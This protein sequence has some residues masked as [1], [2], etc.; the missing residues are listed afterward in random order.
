MF[1]L[2]QE[3]MLTCPCCLSR[4]EIDHDRCYWV[5][6]C[7]ECKHQV[8]II[9]LDYGGMLLDTK[10]FVWDWINEHDIP[11]NDNTLFDDIHRYTIRFFQGNFKKMVFTDKVANKCSED[12]Y[13][14]IC[15]HF[16]DERGHKVRP[17]QITRTEPKIE[18]F[19]VEAA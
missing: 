16:K 14:F 9:D 15:H 11:F 17:H 7:P 8:R 18:T 5:D 10:R 3:N 19:G 2:Q 1:D 13:T 4:W 6:N 12:A